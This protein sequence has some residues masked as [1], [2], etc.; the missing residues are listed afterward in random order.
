MNSRESDSLVITG[1]AIDWVVTGYYPIWTGVNGS[2]WVAANNWKRSDTG[3]PTSFLPGDTVVF[4]DSAGTV[5]GGTTNVTLGSGNVSPGSV[6][7]NNNAYNYSVS[8]AFGI[9]GAG[10]LNLNGTGSVTLS[11][12]NSY[13]GGTNI[14][15]GTLIVN[16]SS[17]VATG[18]GPVNINGGTLQDRQRR[19]H[20]HAGRRAGR[21][22]FRSGL[23]PQ[24]QRPGLSPTRSAAAVPWCSLGPA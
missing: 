8:G 17:G 12:S 5:A 24:R 14:N 23:Q 20:G 11:T 22:Q 2:E 10:S 18:S 9:I 1:T 13:S 15:A 7:F 6:T 19:R 21:Q 4:D 16:N 3:G